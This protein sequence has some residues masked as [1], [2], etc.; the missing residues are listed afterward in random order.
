MDKSR[1]E[2]HIGVNMKEIKS[3]IMAFA[4]LALSQFAVAQVT[5]AQIR[6]QI[7]KGECETAQ[8]L[9]NV[10]KAMNGTDRT[11]ELEIA[12]CFS[13]IR[14]KN[15]AAENLNKARENITKGECDNA[16]WYYSKYKQVLNESDYELERQIDDCLS[17]KKAEEDA[18][19][20]NIEGVAYYNSGNYKQAVGCFWQAANQGNMSA[21]YNLGQLYEAGLGVDKNIETAKIWYQK[22]A[23]QGYDDAR[24][25]LDILNQKKYY[26]VGDKYKFPDDSHNYTVVYVDYTREHGWVMCDYDCFKG[27]MYDD[28]GFK[29][30]W[31]MPTLYEMRKI[32]EKRDALSLCGE[33]WTQTVSKEIINWTF[34]YTID[35]STGKERSRSYD[36]EYYKMYIKDF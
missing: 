11:I 16:Q 24:K 28:S 14:A 35:F 6:E 17:Q 36:K 8:S 12:D 30:G 1:Y 4:L 22:A 5:T 18:A 15:E 3:F 25:R 10:Y 33:F 27:I 20:K 23:D 2:K 31:R 13:A 34:Y 29:H 32:A 21:Q 7:A 9:Y 26:K 19:Q